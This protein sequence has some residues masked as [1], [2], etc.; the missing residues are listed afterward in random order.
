MR[1]SLGLPESEQEA[2]DR[3]CEMSLEGSSKWPPVRDI[4]QQAAVKAV[5][6]GVRPI[7]GG[8]RA[9]KRCMEEN[10]DASIMYAHVVSA[11]GQEAAKDAARII[12]EVVTA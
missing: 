1:F 2:V 5:K 6:A 9:C 4:V 7:D 12:D 10:A 8:G 3:L 11:H